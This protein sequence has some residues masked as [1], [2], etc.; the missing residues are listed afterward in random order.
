MGEITDASHF[1]FF[2]CVRV[3][4]QKSYRTSLSLCLNFVSIVSPPAATHLFTLA[5]KL[6]S[7]ALASSSVMASHCSFTNL[8]S[9]S[10]SLGPRASTQPKKQPKKVQKFARKESASRA[11]PRRRQS[12]FSKKKTN[13]KRPESF[14]L[15]F[16]M[17]SQSAVQL[18]FPH[19]HKNQLLH[20]DHK[21]TQTQTMRS[22]P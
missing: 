14:F 8:H 20:S 10:G 18:F 21:Q 1:G 16:A 12:L 15:N 7:R 22:P 2:Y 9:S 19:H 11:F 3:S 4:V 17:L 6:S 5:G 13:K